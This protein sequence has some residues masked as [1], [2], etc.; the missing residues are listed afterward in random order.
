MKLNRDTFFRESENQI[1]G[2][3]TFFAEESIQITELS[4][5]VIKLAKKNGLRGIAITKG[6]VMVLDKEECIRLANSLGLFFLVL[7]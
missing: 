4:D 1:Q 7:K 5:Q 6:N 3:Y 2:I